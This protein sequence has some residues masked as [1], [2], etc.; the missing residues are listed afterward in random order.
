MPPTRNE[1]RSGTDWEDIGLRD[2]FLSERLWTR[3][4][5]T[6]TAQC[7]RPVRCAYSLQQVLIQDGHFASGVACPS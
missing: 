4:K 3:E 2:L 1:E 6:R 5:A 7:G